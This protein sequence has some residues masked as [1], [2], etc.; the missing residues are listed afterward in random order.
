MRRHRYAHAAN[1]DHE[2][3]AVDDADDRGEAPEAS[4]SQP[5][6]VADVLHERHRREQQQE[7]T[8]DVSHD[9]VALERSFETG[10]GGHAV[11][12]RR[13]VSRPLSRIQRTA[14]AAAKMPKSHHSASTSGIEGRVGCAPRAVAGHSNR[15][16]ESRRPPSTSTRA[17]ATAGRGTPSPSSPAIPRRHGLGGRGRREALSPAH[18][19]GDVRASAW[20][21]T[22]RRPRPRAATAITP[23]RALCTRA[24]GV[25]GNRE[26][27]HQKHRGDAVD[28]LARHEASVGLRPVPVDLDRAGPRPSPT[29]R[30]A[31]PRPTAPADR[32]RPPTRADGRA[33]TATCQGS[34]TMATTGSR[35]PR[36]P[37]EHPTASGQ[38]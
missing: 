34:R 12:F 20:R 32:V 22:R 1:V 4:F 24:G 17:P 23:Q 10:C 36:R 25:G 27:Q 26:R 38:R 14:I 29:R 28:L 5:E 2:D 37:Q 33:A 11:S 13:S 30:D 31:S 21:A 19:A 7:R 18:V 16:R 8:G 9:A 6:G 35:R 15:A 3:P